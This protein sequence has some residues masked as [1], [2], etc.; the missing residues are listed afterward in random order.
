MTV[1]NL[2]LHQITRKIKRIL[3]H[4]RMD[5]TRL[6]LVMGSALWGLQ[7]VFAA[8]IFPTAAQMAAGTGRATYYIMATIAPDYIWG[9][10]FLFQSMYAAYTLFSGARNRASLLMDAVLGCLLW[11]GSTVACYMAYWPMHLPFL[12][13]LHAYPPPAAMSGEAVMAFYSWW[14]M[15][16]H[17][18]EEPADRNFYHSEAG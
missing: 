17:W 2:T 15:I 9:W 1:F 4:D 10:L 14:H 3:I 18:A 11:T 8:D 12:D 5:I 13:A 7:L 16:R 6:G